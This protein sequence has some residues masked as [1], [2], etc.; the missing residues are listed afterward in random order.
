MSVRVGVDLGKTRCRVLVSGSDQ[1][2]PLVV[3]DGARGL[4]EPGGVEDAVATVLATLAR[5]LSPEVAEAESICV[6]AAG[7]QTAPAAAERLARELSQRVFTK[8]VAVVSD[9]VAAHVGAME[10][11]SGVVLAAGTGAVALGIGAEGNVCQVDGWG[12][13]LGD[14]GG[15]AWIGREA[16]RSVLR[17]HESRGRS[18]ALSEAAE[19]RFGDLSGLP[20][21]LAAERNVA[22]T[23]ASFVPDV[24]RCAESGDAET[25][26]ILGRAAAAMAAATAA[27]AEAVQVRRVA[28]VGG[29]TDASL[30]I[31]AWRA[32]LPDGLEVVAATGGAVD[33]ALTLA[34][35]AD[36]PHEARVVRCRS[37]SDVD[38]PDNGDVSALATEQVRADLDDL[39]LRAPEELVDLLLEAEAGV[40]AT[41]A[42]ARDEIA[43]AVRLVEAAFDQGGRLIYVG[44]GTPG[45]LAALDAAECPPTFGTSSDQVVAVLA[46]GLHAAGAAIE[47][48]EDDAEAGARDVSTLNLTEADVVVGISASGRTPFVLSALDA[49]RAR[50]AKTVAVV[51]NPGSPARAGADV[52]IE[53]LTGGEVLAGSTRLKAGSAQKVVLNTL[54]TCAMIRTGK[55]YG[56]WMVDVMTSNHKLRRRAVR[57][58]REVTGLGDDEA[59][60]ALEACGWRTRVALVSVLTGLEPEASRSRLA[61][62]DGRLRD[63]VAGGREP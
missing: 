7:A 15:G 45:R 48:A 43:A 40:P 5:A 29:L 44:A 3:G 4:A 39:D 30:L 52:T 8:E 37:W 57:I 26:L 17:A 6:A 61:A 62:V 21:V 54:S 20:R 24:L 18:T 13:T 63:A 42:R 23:L 41:V 33:G 28:M 1:R 9:A 59:T 38:P 16:L 53:V 25:A 50:G 10:G 35:R 11:A 51:N 19:D 58:V 55:T 12:L 47:G 31:D 22:R 14:D 56:G 34:G 49:A 32:A 2:L 46:G 36:L 27:A 60:R